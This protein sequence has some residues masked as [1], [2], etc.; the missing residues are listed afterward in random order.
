MQS[1]GR[2]HLLEVATKENVVLRRRIEALESENRDLKR[3]VFELSRRLSLCAASANGGGAQ[4]PSSSRND[5][6][7]SAWGPS[8]SDATWHGV[9][10]GYRSRSGSS[11]SHLKVI[12]V[13]LDVHQA[14]QLPR[15]PLD[16]TV[17]L[18]RNTSSFPYANGRN[19][20]EAVEGDKAVSAADGTFRSSDK[21]DSSA[22]PRV[23][24]LN[25][26]I[27]GHKGAVYCGRWS[28]CGRMLA[29]G[30]FDKDVR[31]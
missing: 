9:P 19:G 10:K 13:D 14:Q 18:Q 29:T 7:S 30:S 31:I 8:S 23:F 2:A 12:P 25:A 28:P 3:S 15:N 26:D 22:D 21:K 20:V 6:L 1:S 24:R 27:R 4:M 5:S 11:S 16:G 17:G